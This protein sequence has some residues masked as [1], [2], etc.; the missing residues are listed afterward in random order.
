MLKITSITEDAKQKHTLILPSGDFLVLTISFKPLQT[1][2]FIDELIFKDF[3]LKNMRI[4]LLP[5][6]LLPYVNKL[7]FG[8][9]CFS[10]EEREPTFQQDF[11]S[12]ACTLYLLTEEEKEEYRD[13]LSE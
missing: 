2:W 6:L 9:A 11:S 7:P 12:S 10:D 1:G 4:C 8:L 5:N 3:T 13:F